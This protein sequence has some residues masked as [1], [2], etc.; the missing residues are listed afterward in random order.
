MQA[1]ET[2]HNDGQN[3]QQSDAFS[4][5]P[6]RKAQLFPAYSLF[7]HTGQNPGS[8]MADRNDSGRLATSTEISRTLSMT[9]SAPEALASAPAFQSLHVTDLHADI[10][11]VWFWSVSKAVFFVRYRTAKKTTKSM[12]RA[13]KGYSSTTRLMLRKMYGVLGQDSIGLRLAS[14]DVQGHQ[15][16]ND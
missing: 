3:G 9:P 12:V 16:G 14:G 10:E 6:D 4:K 15:P 5:A 13:M 11:G 1:P 7:F 2:D 8:P